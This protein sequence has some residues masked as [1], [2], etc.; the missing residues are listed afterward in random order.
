VDLELVKRLILTT[1]APTL[2][3]FLAKEFSCIT[4]DLAGM[5][6]RVWRPG[7]RGIGLTS[8]IRPQVLEARS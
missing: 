8:A 7:F 6:L 2:Q 3:K 5:L 1:S 4:R